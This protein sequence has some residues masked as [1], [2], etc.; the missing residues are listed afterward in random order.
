M[1]MTK[2]FLQF[3][4]LRATLICASCVDNIAWRHPR[5][6]EVTCQW[7]SKSRMRREMYC[8]ENRVHD[9]CPQTCG[10]CCEDDSRFTFPNANQISLDCDWLASS[11]EKDFYCNN[12]YLG[13]ATSLTVREGCR[14]T[15]DACFYFVPPI[16]GFD[17]DYHEGIISDD[18]VVA[19][20]ESVTPIPNPNRTVQAIIIFLIIA[21]VA[22]VFTLLMVHVAKHVR[23]RDSEVNDDEEEGVEFDPRKM[24]EDLDEISNSESNKTVESSESESGASPALST[25]ALEVKDR[26]CSP[27]RSSTIR[28]MSSRPFTKR[29]DVRNNLDIG[30]DNKEEEPE[31]KESKPD[32]STIS[33]LNDLVATESR[34]KRESSK[35]SNATP[36]IDS[37]CPFS[38]C[39]DVLSPPKKRKIQENADLLKQLKIQDVENHISREEQPLSPS[40]Q[41]QGVDSMALSTD[42]SVTSSLEGEWIGVERVHP[43]EKTLESHERQGE[44]SMT[45]YHLMSNGDSTV[46]DES[47]TSI[48]STNFTDGSTHFTDGSTHFT[49]GSTH[50][51]EGSTNFTTEVTNF[52]IGPQPNYNS[53]VGLKT[54]VEEGGQSRVIINGN[55]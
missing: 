14:V 47:T 17:D 52:S 43:I 44:I 34:L 12:E 40:S 10:N 27:I 2:L 29:I 9:A 38:C 5:D 51:T 39:Q 30:S 54:Q 4:F 41:S 8:A 36:I 19:G 32:V 1:S 7:I 53:S 48:E 46:F 11:D 18:Q 13:T 25:K 45:A 15:C 3:V 23:K 16:I 26:P 28:E 21:T 42:V 37:I 33:V 49:D 24:V 6:Q 50:F 35:M 55:I 31:K 22:A 20:A